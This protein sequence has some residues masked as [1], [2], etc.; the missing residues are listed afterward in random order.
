M[1]SATPAPQVANVGSLGRHARCTIAALR[2]PIERGL[3][4]ITLAAEATSPRTAEL[5]EELREMT[6]TATT[7]RAT[8]VPSVDPAPSRRFS[9][10][11][12]AG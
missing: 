11:Q 2:T 1:T 9:T 7:D 3:D 8:D 10:A 5:T 4:K 6:D 12:I